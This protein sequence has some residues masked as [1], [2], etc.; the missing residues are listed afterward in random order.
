MPHILL[1]KLALSGLWLSV[2]VLLY[3]C[4]SS[5]YRGPQ[6]PELLAKWTHWTFSSRAV[7]TNASSN[8]KYAGRLIW[9]QR[10]DAFE[11]RLRGPFNITI[12][13]LYTDGD[14]VVLHRLHHE[15]VRAKSLAQLSINITGGTVPVVYFPYWLKGLPSPDAK[16][17]G[18]LSM[19]GRL[20]QWQQAG[21]TVD[22]HHY[23]GRTGVL[24]PAHIILSRGTRSMDM[25]IKGWRA[26][27]TPTL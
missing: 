9:H 6:Q 5:E 20:K 22:I 1:Y 24:L 27:R 14:D 7:W 18:V 12:M 19:D 23:R 17:A 13:R 15:P 11:M 16:V 2:G 8:E 4:A 21:W 25:R 3:G 26:L 10:G